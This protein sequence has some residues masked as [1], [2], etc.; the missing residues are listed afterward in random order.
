MVFLLVFDTP[1]QSYYL[2]I[3]SG[4]GGKES[5]SCAKM[6]QKMYL[7]YA[8][9]KSW[10]TDIIYIEETEFGLRKSVI[11]ISGKGID[12]LLKENGNHRFTRYSPFSKNNK[13]H[14]SFVSVSVKLINNSSKSIEISKDDIEMSFYKGSGAGGQ[15]R[16]KVETGVR[17]VHKPSGI[18]AEAV[19]ERSQ[20]KNREI[21]YERLLSKLKDV[22]DNN[23]SK[24]KQNQWDNL[25]N[26]GFGDKIRTYK[27]D[28]NIIRDELTGNEV[29]NAKKILD[30]NLD[31]I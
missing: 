14:T 11:K 26:M 23:R 21:A 18:V 19:S 24:E 4:E 5:Q 9:K 30:G 25:G 7:K 2:E 12:Q 13:L 16:N 8:F 20:H 15:H 6:L 28:T 22:E 10:K 17:L 29:K 31:L 3:Q 27:L 1:S